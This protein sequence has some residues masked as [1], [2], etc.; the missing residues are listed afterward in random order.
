M[1]QFEA[2]WLP[3]NSGIYEQICRFIFS[4]EYI[5]TS[6]SAC[7]ANIKQCVIQMVPLIVLL[8]GD[9]L[10]SADAINAR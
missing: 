6:T 1:V 8:K 9:S 7:L 4:N 5:L 10:P 3:S 2:S